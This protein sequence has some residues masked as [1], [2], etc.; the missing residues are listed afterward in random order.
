MDNLYH[1]N[2]DPKNLYWY[3]QDNWP[4][5]FCKKHNMGMIGT[6]H[7]DRI[8]CEDCVEPVTLR[9]RLHIY[10]QYVKRKIEGRTL[11]R[12]F[13]PVRI[14]TDG[15]TVLADERREIGEEYFVESKLS[16]TDG[17]LQLMII[18]GKRDGDSKKVQ[19]FVEPGTKRLN[20]DRNSQDQ[21]PAGIFTIVKA[22][23]KGSSQTIEDE[24]AETSDAVTT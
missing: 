24:A 11:A 8:R 7:F 5:P 4:I 10:Q 19:L 20:F 18:A 16:D 15:S 3:M 13:K 14:D 23:F 1:I 22:T 17:G 2:G 21:H 6:D 9:A 12:H